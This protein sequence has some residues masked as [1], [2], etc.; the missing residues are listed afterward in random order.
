MTTPS[1]LLP[2]L[3]NWGLSAQAMSILSREPSI[4]ADLAEARQL[5]P[6]PPGYIPNVIEVLFDDVPYIRSTNGILNF[7]RNCHPDF[8]PQFIEYR[9]DDE[10]A[11]FQVGSEYVINRIEGIAQIYV[12]QRLLHQRGDWQWS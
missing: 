11:I 6:L 4:L 3:T 10:T 1:M 12:L 2:D 8:Q 9:F 7:V 5:P